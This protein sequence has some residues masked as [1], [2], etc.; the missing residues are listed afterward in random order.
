MKTRIEK[1]DEIITKL[2]AA[3]K[4]KNLATLTSV[5]STCVELGINRDEVTSANKM[6]ESLGGSTSKTLNEA[7]KKRGEQMS[8]AEKKLN[9]A[10]ASGNIDKVINA[11]NEAMVLGLTSEVVSKAQAFLSTKG[12]KDDVKSQLE[13]SIKV[14]KVKAE[15]GIK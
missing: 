14:L 3:T 11:L 12:S 5:M 8:G 4:A 6:I 1:E 10:M 2:V 13:A 9:D 15:A 7:N